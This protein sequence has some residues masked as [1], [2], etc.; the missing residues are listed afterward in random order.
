MCF[1]RIDLYLGSIDDVLSSQ[2]MRGDMLLLGLYL[3]SLKCFHTQYIE[4]IGAFRQVIRR[5]VH[6]LIQS[7]D[8]GGVVSAIPFICISYFMNERNTHLI[9]FC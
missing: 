1:S 4:Q 7:R 2:G 6:E 8:Y 3:S 9:F 5:G